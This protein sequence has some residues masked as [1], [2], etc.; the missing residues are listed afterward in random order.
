MTSLRFNALRL[1]MYFWMS[2]ACCDLSRNTA[3]QHMK[4]LSIFND[5]GWWHAVRHVKS[6]HIGRSS[7]PCDGSHMAMD[8]FRWTSDNLLGIRDVYPQLDVV[9]TE[10]TPILRRNSALLSA[11]YGISIRLPTED[12][13]LLNISAKERPWCIHS[14]W[15][16]AHISHQ[17]RPHSNLIRSNCSSL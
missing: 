1:I 2:Y 14:E 17:E 3:R 16:L 10:S 4:A 5:A 13:L 6:R 9:C 12:F 7:W 11:V 8:F 15:F